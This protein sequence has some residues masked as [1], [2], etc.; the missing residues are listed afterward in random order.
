MANDENLKKGKTTRFKTG[1]EQARTARKG[2]IASGEAKREKKTL[3]QLA[4]IM[5]NSSIKGEEKKNVQKL[6]SDIADEDTTVASMMMA[7][8]IKSAM[9]GNTNAFNAISALMKEQEEKAERKEAELK[10]KL[11]RTYHMDLDMIPDVYHPVIR[12]IRNHKHL[13]YVFKGGRGSGK[14]SKIAM[15]IIELI[16]NNHDIHALVCRK[17]GNTLKDSVYAKIKWAIRQQNLSDD[18]TIKRSPL[19]IVYKPT[20]QTIYFRGADEP[21]KIKSI[22][23]E[24]GYIGILWLEEL[25]QY[26]GAEEVRNITQSAIR[27]GDK[28][29]IFKSFNPPKTIN[30]WA[31]QYV[32]AP[33]ENMIVHESTYLDVPI[34]WLGQP[35]IDEAEHLKETNPDAY[36]HEYL[37]KANGTGGNVFEYLEIRNIE[38][39]EINR[40]DR[41]YQGVDFGWYPDYF[42]FVR[43]AYDRA[44]D[45]VYILDEHCCNKQSNAQTGK[46][47]LEHGYDDFH[48]TCDSAE[49]KSINDFKDL[50]LPAR[51]AVKG[52]GSVEY[53]Y[54]WLQCRTIVIDPKRTPYAYKEFTEYEYERDKDGNVLSGYPDAN[55]HVLDA[56]RYALEQFYNKRGTSA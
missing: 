22:S 52:A 24:F 56:T 38:D 2:G 36:E 4:T 28:A 20:G 10:A 46:W 41:I 32:L 21:E 45:K 26:H 11:N 49:P 13:E 5:L 7:G 33:K 31:N 44:Q 25:D 8:Q 54:K 51:G 3:S 6:C 12:D 17:V 18:F 9:R 40:F 30:N 19:E 29:W 47:I 34:E 27:G 15:D 55:N 16:K 14:S 23:P 37:G 53:G 1:E 50:G 39:E 42:A 35:F 43:V 48:I